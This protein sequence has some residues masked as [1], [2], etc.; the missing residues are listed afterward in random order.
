L[1]YKA[2]YVGIREIKKYC[3]ELGNPT[4]FLVEDPVEQDKPILKEWLSVQRD[5]P[6][7]AKHLVIKRCL[8]TA[9]KG[10]SFQMN[11]VE[12][13]VLMEG[14]IGMPGHCPGYYPAYKVTLWIQTHCSERGRK[15]HLLSCLTPAGNAMSQEMYDYT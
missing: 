8:F 14:G 9:K 7:T 10:E 15:C 1:Q 3:D 5:I 4:L 2:L 13:D 12:V 11:P 6:R